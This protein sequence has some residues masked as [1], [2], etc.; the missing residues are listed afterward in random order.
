MPARSSRPVVARAG[1]RPRFSQRD[2]CRGFPHQC[3]EQRSGDGVDP[4]VPCAG[5]R[6]A[7]MALVVPGFVLQDLGSAK[8]RLSP[9]EAMPRRRP[10]V[11]SP[12]PL[13]PTCSL[14]AWDRRSEDC[15]CSWRLARR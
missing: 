1:S 3:S 13:A 7:P 14:R 9:R 15:A 4:W 12:S 8:A 6:A 11:P 10:R 2:R 5:T